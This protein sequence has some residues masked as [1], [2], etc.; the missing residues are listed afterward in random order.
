MMN[1]GSLT[2]GSAPTVDVAVIP[3]EEVYVLYADR[4]YRFCV[5]LLR[6]PSDAEDVTANTFMAAYA[7]YSRVRP[8]ATEL[9]PW[10]FRIARNAS[11]DRL[12]GRARTGRL[13]EVLR[14][15]RPARQEV[16]SAALIRGELRDVVNA[17][18]TLRRR[19]RELVGMR[20]AGELSY[21]EIGAV[22]GIS[23]QA[24]KSATRRALA[25][26]GDRLERTA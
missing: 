11:I 2:C 14:L 3:F 24:A 4:V 19:E 16:E 15:S 9:K 23:E 18:A 6:D 26:L 12:R 5:S 20:V 25:R 17:L 13:L 21:A 1:V 8:P 10:L 7:A 22:L